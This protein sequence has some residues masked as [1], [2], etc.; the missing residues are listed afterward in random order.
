MKKVLKI[1]IKL[2]SI[3]MFSDKSSEFSDFLLKKDGF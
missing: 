1:M 3:E 2:L